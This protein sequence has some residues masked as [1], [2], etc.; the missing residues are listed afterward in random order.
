[1]IKINGFQE[2]FNDGGVFNLIL[3]VDVSDEFYK[4]NDLEKYGY[5]EDSGGYP[6]D[7]WSIWFTQNSEERQQKTAWVYIASGAEDSDFM[8]EEQIQDAIRYVKK[9]RLDV[10]YGILLP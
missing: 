3:D 1:M 8:T 4:T 2:A 5:D 10:Q 6:K 9:N 7:K